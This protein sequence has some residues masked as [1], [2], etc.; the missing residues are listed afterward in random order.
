MASAAVGSSVRHG[1]SSI[2]R[3]NMSSSMDGSVRYQLWERLWVFWPRPWFARYGQRSSKMYEYSEQFASRSRLNIAGSFLMWIHR[4]SHS[5]D[6]DSELK[7]LSVP[8][9]A[10][11]SDR[12]NNNRRVIRTW[13]CDRDAMGDGE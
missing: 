10:P 8:S 9:H 4:F 6:D 11:G 7:L 1:Y 3:W 13:V 5:D 12:E 2:L